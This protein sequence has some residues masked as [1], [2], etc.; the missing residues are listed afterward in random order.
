MAARRTI[1]FEKVGDPMAAWA[2]GF[3]AGTAGTS[4]SWAASAMT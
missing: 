4:A 1:F 2:A 3:A